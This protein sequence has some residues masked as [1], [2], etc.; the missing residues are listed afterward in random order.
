MAANNDATIYFY[1]GVTVDGT[2]LI[3][4]TPTGNITVQGNLLGDTTNASGWA[5]Q[6]RVTFASG[7]ASSPQ[8]LEAMSNDLGATLS[9]FQN[10]FDYA[11]IDLTYYAYVQLVDQS[12]NVPGETLPNAVY[13][14][15][16]TVP[17]GATLD[18]NGLH[19]YTL[20]SNVQGMVLNGTVTIVPGSS[21]PDLSPQNIS[22]AGDNT[23]TVKVAW[24][25]VNSGGSDV[26]T[27]FQ[28]EVQ[29][30][31][32]TAGNVVLASTTTSYDETSS[33]PLP[34]NGGAVPEQVTF[35]LASYSQF[36]V[37]DVLEAIIDVDVN[38]NVS[39]S[40]KS[41][42][43]ATA[44]VTQAQYPDLTVTNLK[45][46]W[47]AVG[48]VSVQWHDSNIGQGPVTQDFYDSIVAVDATTDATV[49]SNDVNDYA[50][51]TPIAGGASTAE[52]FSFTLPSGFD[53]S[54]SLLITVTDDAGNNIFETNES[55]NAASITVSGPFNP[56]HAGVQRLERADD[57]VR[58]RRHD[59]L[60][61]DLAGA[62]RRTNLRHARRRYAD[63]YRLRRRLCY[64]LRHLCAWA[65]QVRR[66]QSRT[67]TP[68]TRT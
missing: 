42:N 8:L 47:N 13:T 46:S 21:L 60:R 9:G 2:G 16:L 24:N 25:D 43:Q 5:P 62:R 17:A 18:L 59:A 11:S 14:A 63:G 7:S 19:L 68:A 6:G 52:S 30:V 27:S 22:A 12:A 34:F 56:F 28:D 40:N 31:D 36:Q 67:R 50:A 3:S 38:D 53:T 51:Q 45:G 55:N 32:V 61:F 64:Q 66:T 65:W 49:Y 54:H 10:N 48:L 35:S 57:H 58:N 41:N 29:L 20:A 33:G 26:T 15:A 37:G 1:S 4:S 39:E 23:G 44:A